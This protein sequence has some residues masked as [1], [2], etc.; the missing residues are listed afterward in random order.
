[1]SKKSRGPFGRP[2]FE[3]TAADRK[4]VKELSGFGV[5]EDDIARVIVNLQMGKPITAKT[6]RKHFRD[7]LDTGL[8]KANAEIARAL[9]RKAKQGDNTCMIFWLKTRA[10][11]KDTMTLEHTGPEGGPIEYNDVGFTDEQRVSRI[12]A[13][14][15]AARTRRAGKPS[16][17]K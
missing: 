11:W 17:N 2:T 10:H 4:Y 6:L 13:L 12:A 7:E 3:P 9:Y 1:M 5:P 16:A 15:E 14:F 8:V